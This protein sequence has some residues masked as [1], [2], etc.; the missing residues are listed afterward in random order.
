MLGTNI[1]VCGARR[2]WDKCYKITSGKTEIAATMSV[3]RINSASV[4][5]NGKLLWVTGGM[6]YDKENLASSE[7][8]DVDGMTN[9]GPELPQPLSFHS[10]IN[11]RY[12]PSPQ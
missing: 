11:T 8:I 12:E 1:V 9:P 3:E 5:I 2:A 7:F 4:V 6:R 10:M